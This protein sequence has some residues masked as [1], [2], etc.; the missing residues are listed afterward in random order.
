MMVYCDNREKNDRLDYFKKFCQ[1]NDLT[2]VMKQSL[3][4][5]DYVF[6]KDDVRVCF[7]YKTI[8]D[9][10]SS[11]MDN[12]VFNQAINMAESFD[13]H[14]VVV[15]G[16]Y[17][18]EVS[19]YYQIGIRQGRTPHFTKRMFIGTIT[20][21]NTVSHVLRV[22]NMGEAFEFMLSQARKCFSYKRVYRHDNRLPKGVGQ[23]LVCNVSGVADT[24]A[25]L[26]ED[27]L[28]L[29]TLQD[30]LN[31]EKNDLL[32]IKGIGEKTADKIMERIK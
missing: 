7:E 27:S 31:V 18:N 2:R 3:P 25:S 23:W 26:I 9:F 29:D 12:R 6:V 30:L 22:N 17:N 24:T 16:D 14:Y 15:V 5:G 28:G 19:K 21:L 32:S 11:I 1:E 4:V 13:Y 10:I 8:F 20:S